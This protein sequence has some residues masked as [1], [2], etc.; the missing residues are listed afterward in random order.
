MDLK[1]DEL[2]HPIENFLS[3]NNF[4]VN[5]RHKNRYYKHN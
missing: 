3:N 2:L 5:I 4:G 1:N